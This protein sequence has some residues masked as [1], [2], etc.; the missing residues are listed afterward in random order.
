MMTFITNGSS[1][2]L[3]WQWTVLISQMSSTINSSVWKEILFERKRWS[4]R[5]NFR[6]ILTCYYNWSS[7]FNTCNTG[8]TERMGWLTRIDSQR[9]NALRL[10]PTSPDFTPTTIAAIFVGGIFGT[11][12]HGYRSRIKSYTAIKS[13]Y[14]LSTYD[15]RKMLWG[16]YWMQKN[17]IIIPNLRY[18]L[19]GILILLITCDWCFSEVTMYSTCLITFPFF[20]GSDS[21][22]TLYSYFERNGCLPPSSVAWFEDPSLHDLSNRSMRN[23]LCT[24]IKKIYN[25]NTF[26]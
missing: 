10:S 13:E 20:S 8:S 21:T 2:K 9:L 1:N 19:I 3:I 4:L 5:Y 18:F 26:I 14:L 22:F 15:E 7:I 25:R 23:P 12:L 17:R 16:I 11:N 24:Y 6:S